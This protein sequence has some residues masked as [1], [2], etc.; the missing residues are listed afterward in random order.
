MRSCLLY[1]LFC[2]LLYSQNYPYR[3]IKSPPIELEADVSIVQLSPARTGST[4][5][6]NVLNYLFEDNQI[7]S[8]TN[9]RVIKTH[10][11]KD[12]EREDLKKKRIL[13][14]KT[15]REPLNV[16][17][18]RKLAK[19]P[20]NIRGIKDQILSMDKKKVNILNILTFRYESFEKDQFDYIF[21]VIEEGLEIKIA[22]DIKA[23]VAKIFC[24]DSMK[25]LQGK[26][27]DFNDFEQITGLHGN[28]IRESD[29]RRHLKL[30][31]ALEAYRQNYEL[32]RAWGYPLFNVEKAWFDFRRQKR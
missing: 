30:I 10:N 29:W 23:Y 25:K 18:S 11:I 22:E 5:I 31:E 3:E 2:F 24:I 19:I 8:G 15:V 21:S 32:R 9:A 16:I 4:L 20:Y 28:H 7:G 14:C 27:K 26:L 6:Y 12:L 13:L 1:L 17:A